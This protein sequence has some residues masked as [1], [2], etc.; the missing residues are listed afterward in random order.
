MG[1]TTTIDKTADFLN[2]VHKM[3]A[4][5]VMVGIPNDK[6]SR[7]GPIG[8]AGLGYIHEFGSALQ[9]IPARPFL[10]PG[11]IN[12]A[13]QI[14]KHMIKAMDIGPEVAFNRAGLS[15]VTSV[16][17]MIRSQEGFEPLAPS[18]LA[19]RERE[20]FKGTKALIHTGQLLNSV[21]YVIRKA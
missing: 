17:K 21:T 13:E 8:N 2:A 16:K 12:A 20:G 11:V 7:D 10:Y 3:I 15:A 5:D 9:N 18:T 6:D 1:V 4:L 14:S 19:A